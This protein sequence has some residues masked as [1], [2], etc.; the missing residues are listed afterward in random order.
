MASILTLTFFSSKDHSGQDTWV[1]KNLDK[2]WVNFIK[3]SRSTEKFRSVFC[4]GLLLL[5][6]HSLRPLLLAIFK[7]PDTSLLEESNTSFNDTDRVFN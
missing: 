6:E 2:I 1:K 3:L 7:P 5:V 4:E